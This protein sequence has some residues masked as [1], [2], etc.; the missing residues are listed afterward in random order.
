MSASE[1]TGLV[2]R[3]AAPEA[4]GALLM[5]L[6]KVLSSRVAELAGRAY[7]PADGNVTTINGAAFTTERSQTAIRKQIAT[8][9]I[10]ARKLGG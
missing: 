7:K 3:V 4:N 1:Q 2:E 8:G 6:V 10:A 5:A 9:E